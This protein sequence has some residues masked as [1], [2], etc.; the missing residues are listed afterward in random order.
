MSCSSVERLALITT[1]TVQAANPTMSVTNRTK[2]WPKTES[3]ASR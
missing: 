2:K 3:C 1:E